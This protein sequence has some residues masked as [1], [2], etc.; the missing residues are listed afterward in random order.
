M[1]WPGITLLVNFFPEATLFILHEA[2]LWKLDLVRQDTGGNKAKLRLLL[3]SHLRRKKIT[4]S[5][6]HLL[7]LAVRASSKSQCVTQLPNQDHLLCAGV[8]ERS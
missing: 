7:R 4:H 5:A 3:V 6:C 1:T 2:L 8:P